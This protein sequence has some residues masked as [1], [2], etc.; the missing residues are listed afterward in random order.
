MDDGKPIMCRQCGER[1]V[2]EARRCYATPVCYACLP[3]PKPLP[4]R[5]KCRHCIH[6]E[7]MGFCAG[8]NG[9]TAYP[10]PCHHAADPSR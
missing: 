5:R 1:E 10:C 3:P 2:E 7:H 8:R 9:G 6:D 4:V